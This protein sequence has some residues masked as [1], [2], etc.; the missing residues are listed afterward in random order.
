MD[1][2]TR[3]CRRCSVPTVSTRGEILLDWYIPPHRVNVLLQS[4][5]VFK[6]RPKDH[7]NFILST[8]FYGKRVSS[9]I[10]DFSLYITRKPHSSSFYFYFRRMFMFLIFGL[11]WRLRFSKYIL[12]WWNGREWGLKVSSSFVPS[13]RPASAIV[14]PL[15]TVSHTHPPTAPMVSV[16]TPGVRPYRKYCT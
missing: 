11:R 5:S 9:G 1:C 6:Y 4:E 15:R 13:R 12:R 16:P 2:P 14:V 8:Y 10:K 3:E 7:V